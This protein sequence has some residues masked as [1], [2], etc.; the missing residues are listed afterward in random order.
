MKPTQLTADLEASIAA[1]I[2][3]LVAALGDPFHEDARLLHYATALEEADR[4]SARK[5]SKRPTAEFLARVD[6]FLAAHEIA[7]AIVSKRVRHGDWENMTHRALA[8]FD[9]ESIR[10]GHVRTVARLKV[11]EQAFFAEWNEGLP[12][13]TMVFWRMIARAGLPYERRDLLAEIL[14]RGRITSREHYEFAVDAIGIAE[15]ERGLSAAE[16][17]TLGRMIDA[18]EARYQ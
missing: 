7:L 1:R 11:L 12:H 5:R 2:A 4:A 10:R 6:A 15:D 9:V 13:N 17:D 8:L 14:E 18:Y 16:V 3:R